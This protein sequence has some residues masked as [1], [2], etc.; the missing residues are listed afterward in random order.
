MARAG[1]SVEHRVRKVTIFEIEILQYYNKIIV[2]RVLC[3]KGTYIRSLAQDFV[4]AFG[5]V[6]YLNNLIRTRIGEYKIS[7][8]KEISSI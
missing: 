1:K 8:S 2:F 5:T 3:S 4:H 7:D 6:G